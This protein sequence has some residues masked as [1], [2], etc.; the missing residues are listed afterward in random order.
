ME[1]IDELKRD[2]LDSL[3]SAGKRADG[4][5]FYDFRKII[6]QKDVLQNAEGS[7]IVSIGNTQVLVGIKF[8]IAMPFPDKPNEGVLSTSADLLPLASH[9]FETGPPGDESIELA[10]VV[11][12]GIRSANVLDLES[13]F[14]EPEKV[15]GIYIDISVLDHDGNLFDASTLAAM[16]ALMST[17]MPKIEDGKIV[18]GEYS[19]KLQIK[20]KVVS[21]TFGKLKNY[22]FLDPSLDEEKGMD[23]RLTIAT[24][25]GF[26]CAAQKG[27]SGSFTENDIYESIELAFEKGE[28]LRALLES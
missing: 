2:N 22:K 23:A 27:G 4:R 8:D 19:G 1:T 9:L 15:L 20:N 7:A 28:K 12:R 26:V 21:C 5:G 11:D 6:I 16:A 17:K 18:R 24:V 3:L 14:I 25:P 13:F 10:R